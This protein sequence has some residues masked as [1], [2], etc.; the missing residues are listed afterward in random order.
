MAIIWL[1]F[2]NRN[3]LSWILP[4]PTLEA[5]LEEWFI[6]GTALVDDLELSLPVLSRAC[7]ATTRDDVSTSRFDTSTE[8][9]RTASHMIN[10][11]ALP[12]EAATQLVLIAARPDLTWPDCLP[13]G[14]PWTF[15]S[16]SFSGGDAPKQV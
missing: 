7:C 9:S 11:I 15:S 5:A 2:S 1:P 3:F 8:D 14:I 10:Q 6:T 13:S 12:I 4:T 16:S